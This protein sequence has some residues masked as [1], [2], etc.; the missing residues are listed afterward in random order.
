MGTS[1]ANSARLGMVYR[2]PATAVIGPYAPPPA[3]DQQ[4]EPEGDGEAHDHGDERERRCAPM[5]SCPDVVE[6]A[7]DPVPADQRPS[8]ASQLASLTTATSAGSDPD[9]SRAPIPPAPWRSASATWSTVSTPQRAPG[10]VDHDTRD[11]VR[12]EHHGQRVPERHRAASGAAAVGS[13]RSAVRL[14]VAGCALVDPAQRSIVL[15]Q[16][17]QPWG[18]GRRGA[19]PAPRPHRRPRGAGHRGHAAEVADPRRA[20]GASDHGRLPRSGP[21]TRMPGAPGSRPACSNWAR[22]PPVWQTAT[23][24]PS[25]IAS[26]MSWVTNRMVRASCSWSRSSSSWSRSRTI[27]ST[28]PNGSSMSITRRVGGK[29]PGHPHPLALAA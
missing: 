8:G 5:V 19:G 2:I 21:R 10:V 27:G 11:D 28:A 23:R 16:Q 29:R 24:S 15:V 20:T 3:H 14:P 17:Q 25:R 6:V 7:A 18:T 22:M 4:R 26:S 13:A 9:P 1:A 12:V